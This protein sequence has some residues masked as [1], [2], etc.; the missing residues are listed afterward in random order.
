MTAR[1]AGAEARGG[2]TDGKSSV[3]STLSPSAAL[4][5]AATKAESQRQ[6]SPPK[7]HLH[8]RRLWF[9]ELNAWYD[10]YRLI[11]DARSRFWFNVSPCL[12]Y[13]RL[14][15]STSFSALVP[16][17]LSDKVLRPVCLW[18]TSLLSPRQCLLLDKRKCQRDFGKCHL[19][20]LSG[21]VCNPDWLW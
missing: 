7:T 2:G 18:L 4:K 16:E 6:C 12:L 15:T 17:S 11:L 8:Q 1:G 20:Q 9:F 21:P 5:S 14:Q 13:S 3:P 10:G 19:S